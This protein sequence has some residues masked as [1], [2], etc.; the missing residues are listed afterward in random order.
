MKLKYPR[1]FVAGPNSWTTDNPNNHPN[2]YLRVDNPD[3]PR[4][5]IITEDGVNLGYYSFNQ[6]DI[7]RGYLK[8]VAFEEL[9]F[10]VF[11]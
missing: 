9:P 4:M 8:E 7:N 6:I 1:Y 11:I 3:F 2:M 10:L 5:G